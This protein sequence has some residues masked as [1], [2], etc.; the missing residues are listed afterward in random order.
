[1]RR[2]IYIYMMQKQWHYAIVGAI[3]VSFFY[4]QICNFNDMRVASAH[5]QTVNASLRA[6][7][8]RMMPH[9]RKDVANFSRIAQRKNDTLV[10]IKLSRPKSGFRRGKNAH[11]YTCGYLRS[12]SNNAFWKAIFPDYLHDERYPSSSKWDVI[13]ASGSCEHN[14]NSFRGTVVYVD[15][16]G[17]RVQISTKRPILYLGMND[18]NIIRNI[19]NKQGLK[20]VQSI[21]VLWGAWNM[22]G[23]STKEQLKR[24]QEPRAYQNRDGFMAYVH[25][26]C[27]PHREKLF[28]SFVELA[29]A[30]KFP[31]PTAYGKCV[32]KY[33]QTKAKKRD[34]GYRSELATQALMA[35]CRFV[36]SGEPNKNKGYFTEKIINAFVSGAIPVVWG[37][38]VVSDIFNFESYIYVGNSNISAV[39]DE[40]KYLQTNVSAYKEKLAKPILNKHSLKKYFSLTDTVGGGF[41]K[42]KIR[43]AVL[44]IQNAH[45]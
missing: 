43:R 27:R 34:P 12:S 41:L 1:V 15:G 10:E 17:H 39:L 30:N 16:E 2:P 8:V 25:S 20:I 22:L 4:S 18:K 6:N 35:Q 9:K 29:I 33:P 38:E 36:L 32:G 31:L 40:V 7:I 44:Q 13:L 45:D 5:H 37:S 28:N 11:V 24:L 23:A 42:Q 26:N 3:I 21:H 19:A 14:L